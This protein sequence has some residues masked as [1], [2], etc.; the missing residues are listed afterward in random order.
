MLRRRIGITALAAAALAAIAASAIAATAGAETRAAKDVRLSLVAYS[1]PREAYAKLIPAFQKTPEGDGVS[2]TQSYG[3][4]GEQARAVKAGLRADIVAL[5]LAPDIDELVKAGLVDAKWNRQ[6]YKG[7]GPRLGRG[8]RRPRRQPEEDQDLGRPAQARRRGDHAEPVHVR[9][10]PLERDGRVRVLDQ[11]QEDE[12]AGSGEAAQA[13]RERR[14]FRTRARATPRTPSSRARE[15]CCSRTRTR[16]SP[17]SA[18][19]RRSS[20]SSRA[21]PS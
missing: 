15:T 6:S 9:R 4:S 21:R 18:P 3:S 11:A 2:F 1:T 7:H 16:P 12:E 5:S 17:P 13:V 8:V 20:T 14:P 10:R 19:A